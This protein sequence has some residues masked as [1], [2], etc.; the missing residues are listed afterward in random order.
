MAKLTD[1]QKLFIVKAL[2]CFESPTRVAN[3]FREQFGIEVSRAQV[4]KYDPTKVAGGEV[5]AKLVVVFDETRRAF[6][7]GAGDVPIAYKSFRL[8]SLYRMH[9]KAEDQGNMVLAAQLLEQ[10]AKEIG[11]AFTNRRELT[12][13]SGGPIQAA[14]QTTTLTDERFTEIAKR[15]LNEV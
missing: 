9:Q 10:A 13:A 11:G 7:D 1:P 15:L 4:A 2:A 8:H 5:S 12:G 14:T 3:S 6:K